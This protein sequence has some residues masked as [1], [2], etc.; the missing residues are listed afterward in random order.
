[1]RSET[2]NSAPDTRLSRAPLGLGGHSFREPSHRRTGPSQGIRWSVV[3][4]NGPFLVGYATVLLLVAIVAFGP[5][6][7]T[8]SPY[9]AGQPAR[10]SERGEVASPPFAPSAEWPLGTDRW[11]RDMLSLL[12]YG[13]RETLTAC[14]FVTMVRVALGTALGAVAGWRAGTLLDLLMMGMVKAMSAL[15]MLLAGMILM[16]APDIRRGLDAFLIALCLVGWGEVAQTM[17][18]EFIAIRERPF[19][20]GARVGGRS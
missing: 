20:E 4:H 7:A 1:V 14:A 15:P 8:E 17:R 5:S 16:L 6:L 13:A 10:T 2:G 19:I 18:A 3:F 9:C 11:G 12:L